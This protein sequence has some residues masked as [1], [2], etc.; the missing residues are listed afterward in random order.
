ML[1]LAKENKFSS[2]E[3]PADIYLT[4]D[5]FSV[6][7]NILTPTFKLKRNIGKEV[8]Q[9]QIDAL[10]DN[11]TKMEAAREAARAKKE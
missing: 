3:R 4:L 1:R 9:E 2:L 6:E 10:Y 8:Y 11:V 5:P 7:N